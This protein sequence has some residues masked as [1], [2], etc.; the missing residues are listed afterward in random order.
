MLNYPTEMSRTRLVAHR[1]GPPDLGRAHANA[2]RDA[3]LESALEAVCTRMKDSHVRQALAAF[4][5]IAAERIEKI[6]GG[7]SSHT[8][9]V[10]GELI[11]RFARFDVVARNLRREIAVLPLVQEHVSFGVPVPAVDR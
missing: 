11:F 8:F 1:A 4:P 10:N 9:L 7:W 3:Y 5:D 2:R 6:E